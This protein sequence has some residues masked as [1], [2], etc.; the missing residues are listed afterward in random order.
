MFVA[1]E[2]SIEKKAHSRRVDARV[3]HHAR[4][5]RSVV[6]AIRPL[7]LNKEGLELV[8]QTCKGG[9]LG[10]A[11]TIKTPSGQWRYICY[12]HSLREIVL[13]TSRNK[14]EILYTFT[15]NQTIAQMERAIDTYLS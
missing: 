2:T 10:S 11:V 1:I 6:G 4:Q 7:I 13:K 14:G 9:R 8:V 3:E 12:D 5:L 15:K